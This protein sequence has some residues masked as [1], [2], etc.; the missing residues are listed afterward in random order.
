M[1][2]NRNANVQP[3][4]NSR[5]HLKVAE[6]QSDYINASPI[7]L[8]DSRTGAV[9]KFIATQGPKESTLSHFWHMVWQE[10][11]D[12]AV[13]VMLTQTHDGSTEK[14]FQYFPLNVEIR[15]FEIESLDTARNAPKGDV[16]L[17]KFYLDV[18]SRTEVRKLSLRFGV[19]TKD[20]WH[21]LFLDWSDFI[22][23]EDDDRIALLNLLKLYK[24][25]N[26]SPSNPII[27]H[28][29]AE[30]GRTGT[31]IAVE[32]L[33]AQVNSGAISN[34]KESEDPIYDMVNH[35]R[36]QRMLMVQS[37]IQYQFLYDVTLEQLKE[38]FPGMKSE[39]EK[40]ADLRPQ[41]SF[42]K[43]KSSHMEESSWA[44][45]GKNKLH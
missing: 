38:R 33:L 16:T 11:T 37:D 23:P 7:S 6:G 45:G 26:T 32:H 2:R 24:K 35:L 13:I 5:I 29:S 17:L 20:V 42:G 25:R 14:C 4:E 21:F 9:T 18:D 28:N 43:R 41:I 22:V 34:A 15:S 12:V 1:K 27:V 36:E 8:R 10:T 3:W 19:E 44:R 40:L 39:T 31:F 30:V